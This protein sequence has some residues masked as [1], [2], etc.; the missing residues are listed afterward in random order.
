MGI[1]NKFPARSS[2]QPEGRLWNVWS[3]LFFSLWHKGFYHGMFDKLCITALWVSTPGRLNTAIPTAWL[4][5]GLGL[6]YLFHPEHLSQSARRHGQAGEGL[7]QNVGRCRAPR[8]SVTVREDF[9]GVLVGQQRSWKAQTP[10]ASLCPLWNCM[11]RLGAASA[12]DTQSWEE[13]QQVLKG[14]ATQGSVDCNR[15]RNDEWHE[16]TITPATAN[17][18]CHM[19]SGIF[20]GNQL[21]LRAA[22]TKWAS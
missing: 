5:D 8:G 17:K 4:R 20:Q 18:P 9:L 12:A 16:W 14:L 7:F 22:S 1:R 3:M 11:W 15:Y 10:M 2:L 19:E 21:S 13:G 6:K